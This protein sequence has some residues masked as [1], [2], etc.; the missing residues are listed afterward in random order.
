MTEKKCPYCEGT[1]VAWC[2]HIE[3]PCELEH[4]CPVCE[5]TGTVTEK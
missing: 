2:E 1:G 4:T 5:G 3:V